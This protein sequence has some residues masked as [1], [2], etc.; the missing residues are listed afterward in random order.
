MPLC[1]VHKKGAQAGRREFQKLL[2]LC[3]PSSRLVVYQEWE[4]ACSESHKTAVHRKALTE[5]AELA[6]ELRRV[7]L[8]ASKEFPEV[9]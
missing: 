1:R 4:K 6:A 5:A 7:Q 9:W 2:A 8:E 3:P